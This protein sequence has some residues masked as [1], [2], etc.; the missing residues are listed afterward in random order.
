MSSVH[1]IQLEAASSCKNPSD[2]EDEEE[3]KETEKDFD[4]AAGDIQQTGDAACD[5]FS[6]A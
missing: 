4:A 3:K 6:A 1:Q 2:E 5:F